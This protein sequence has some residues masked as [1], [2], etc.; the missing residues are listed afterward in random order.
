MWLSTTSCAKA[1]TTAAR[2]RAKLDAP[3]NCKPSRS[4][5]GRVMLLLGE[6]PTRFASIYDMQR[7]VGTS[8]VLY[9]A[10]NCRH[11]CPC[12]RC[13]CVVEQR[14]SLKPSRVNCQGGQFAA[15]VRLCTLTLPS[16]TSLDKTYIDGP[17]GDR[18][19]SSMSSEFGCVQQANHAEQR[20]TPR[21]N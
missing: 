3:H 16:T 5:H 15:V 20:M 8:A 14:A 17:D 13:V 4:V 12:M 10:T 9:S 19:R 6:F 11:V 1:I 21:C 18:R 2:R 7:A